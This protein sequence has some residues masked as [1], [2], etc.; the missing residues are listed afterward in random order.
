M[1]LLRF[2]LLNEFGAAAIAFNNG[3]RMNF[4]GIKVRY[5][6]HPVRRQ[7]IRGVNR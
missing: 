1:R 7:G 4:K 5:L 3:A 2:A 6:P